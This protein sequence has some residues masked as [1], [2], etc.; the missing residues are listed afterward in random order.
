[1]TKIDKI[2]IKTKNLKRKKK[3]MKAKTRNNKI[4]SMK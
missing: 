1:M 3:Y 2:E 4:K